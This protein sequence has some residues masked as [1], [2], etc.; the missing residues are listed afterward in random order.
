MRILAHPLLRRDI[1]GLAQHVYAVSGSA[2]AAR[3]R[4]REVHELIGQVLEDP[5]LGTLL[6][7]GLPEW[8]VRHGGARRRITVVFRHDAATAQTY[9]ALVAFGGENW[10]ARTNTRTG[11]F[12]EPEE[13]TAARKLK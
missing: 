4:I 6:G 8:R 3:R 2:D 13:G 10:T 1:E 7:D 5:T 9:I 12:S 11:Y